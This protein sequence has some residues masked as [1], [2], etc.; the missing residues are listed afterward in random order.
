MTGMHAASAVS[1]VTSEGQIERQ[2]NLQQLPDRAPQ[3]Q[4]PGY[5]QVKPQ[6]Q[7]SAGLK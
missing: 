2:E 5:L 1:E 3:G 4:G 6:A 7:A